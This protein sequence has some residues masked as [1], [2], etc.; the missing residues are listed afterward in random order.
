LYNDAIAAGWTGI[1]PLLATVTVETGVYI[2]STNINA[3]AFTTGADMPAG[4]IITIINNGFIMGQG[5]DGA[6]FTNVS[7]PAT[8]GGT[9]LDIRCPG[10]K[11]QATSYIGGGGGGGGHGGSGGGATTTNYNPGAIAGTG[12]VG[13]PR[14]G[15]NGGPANASTNGGGGGGGL[16]SVGSVNGGNGHTSSISGVSTVY[17]G[18]GRGST[19]DFQ[20]YGNPGT[21]Q[22]NRGGGG[23]AGD[24]SDSGKAGILIIRYPT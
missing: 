13:P 23:N 21:G 6:G 5:G 18:G 22:A 8:S 3:P 10:V 7:F 12:V 17:A 20:T 11:I 16:G 9:A 19:G 4:S 15:R 14:Q 1:T 24:P 2:Y